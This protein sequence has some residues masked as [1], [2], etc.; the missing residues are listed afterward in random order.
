MPE[1]PVLRENQALVYSK[2]KENRMHKKKDHIKA[3]HKE[4]ITY[5][6]LS[7]EWDD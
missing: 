3:E 4:A 5:A 1:H 7:S 2:R 6:K